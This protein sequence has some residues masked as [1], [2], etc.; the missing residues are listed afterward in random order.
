MFT[1]SNGRIPKRVGQDLQLVVDPVRLL[2]VLRPHPG[3]EPLPC[4]TSM[5]LHV[6]QSVQGRQGTLERL[7]IEVG[8]I[9]LTYR[10]SPCLESFSLVVKVDP[11]GPHLPQNAHRKAY[12]K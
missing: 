1:W 4:V 3:Q 9:A 6:F 5:P 8:H 12:P 10:V 11:Q 2:D 7:V